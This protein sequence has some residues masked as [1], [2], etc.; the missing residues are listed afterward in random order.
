MSIF[1]HRVCNPLNVKSNFQ[2]ERNL[3]MKKYLL[4]LTILLHNKI[5]DY[6]DNAIL[7]ILFYYPVFIIILA[8]LLQ[9]YPAK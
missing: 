5:F 8:R 4:I 9:L 1:R 3:K 2:H 6:F 7:F